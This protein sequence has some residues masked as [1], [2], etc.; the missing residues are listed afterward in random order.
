M[1][2]TYVVA[3]ANVMQQANMYPPANAVWYYVAKVGGQGEDDP[4]YR[5]S[6]L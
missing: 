3:Q 6:L 4:A 5:C 2:R 1:R